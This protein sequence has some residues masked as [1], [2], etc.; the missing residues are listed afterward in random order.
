MKEQIKRFFSE[1]FDSSVYLLLGGAFCG[2]V[3]LLFIRKIWYSM[4]AKY[5]IIIIIG[6]LIACILIYIIW[7]LINHLRILN[8]IKKDEELTEIEKKHTKKKNEKNSIIALKVKIKN[9]L[10][11][12]KSK[13]LFIS[14][15]PWILLIGEPNSGKST[16]IRKSELNFPLGEGSLPGNGGTVNCDWWFT[17][18]AV[19]LDTAGRYTFPTESAPDKAEWRAFLKIVKKKRKYVSPINAVILTISAE[20]LLKN[21]HHDI[22][23]NAILI[24]EKLIELTSYLGITF[25]VY[26]MIS[27]MDQVFGFSEFFSSISYVEKSQIFGLDRKE[28][29]TGPFDKKE[30]RELFDVQTK[31]LQNWALRRAKDLDHY[32]KEDKTFHICSFPCAF[33]YLRKPLELYLKK[34]FQHDSYN[35]NPK[36]M[37]PLMWRG[38]YFSSSIQQE[39]AIFGNNLSDESFSRNIDLINQDKHHEEEISNVLRKSSRPYF[40]HNII[41]KVFSEHN[42]GALTPKKIRNQKIFTTISAICL[43]FII[44]FSVTSLNIAQRKLTELLEPFQHILSGDVKRILDQK[45]SKEINAKKTTSVVKKFEKLRHAI[46]RDNILIYYLKKS[47]ENI[48]IDNLKHIESLIVS[49]GLKQKIFQKSGQCFHEIKLHS[50]KQ[51]ENTVKALNQYLLLMEKTPVSKI[52]PSPLFDLMKYIPEKRKWLDG[53][54][55][56]IHQLWK[57]FPSYDS[58]AYLSPYETLINVRE[59]LERL[60]DY[61][62]L[63]DRDNWQR[64]KINY[65]SLCKAYNKL[66]RHVNKKN[67]NDFQKKT[68]LI[69]RSNKVFFLPPK[70]MM[71]QKCLSDYQ[72]IIHT[73]EGFEKSNIIIPTVYR[74][75]ED[76][77]ALKQDKMINAA[78]ESVKQCEFDIIINDGTINPEL[79]II[80]QALKKVKNFKPI[81]D[82]LK[83]ILSNISIILEGIESQKWQKEVLLSNIVQYC[84]RLVW[85]YHWN[86]FS[87][88]WRHLKK[89]FP[90][91]NASPEI[92]NIYPKKERSS[93]IML[94]DC[95]IE[96]LKNFFFGE[97]GINHIISIKN[98][99]EK[100]VGLPAEKCFY[101]KRSKAFIKNCIQWRNFLFIDENTPRIHDIQLAIN[102][103]QNGNHT[104]A[105]SRFTLLKILGLGNPM[106]LRFSGKAKQNKTSW[107]L[108][109]SNEIIIEAI[110]EQTDGTKDI[111]KKSILYIRGKSLAFPAYILLYGQ[112]SQVFGKNEW[113]TNFKL[114]D[115]KLKTIIN[116]SIS[117]YWKEL[118]DLIKWP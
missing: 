91:R 21:N 4:G 118:P 61:W 13:G 81:K 113:K 40:I 27:K 107:D 59:G 86:K 99:L 43:F 88:Q 31:R 89:R 83:L 53:A 69:P 115:L 25:P 1:M 100:Q 37:I 114:P 52:N 101:T 79:S 92:I 56:D 48:L 41:R 111:S 12:L 65:E 39:K 29:L 16:F 72:D 35:Q 94:K 46:K 50:E 102:S 14:Q 95:S 70:D 68:L 42:L 20:T 47:K 8:K 74:H 15:L 2:A 110:K 85:Q 58:L 108:S 105:S 36:N 64:K 66:L 84:T 17:D 19:I 26:I 55:E 117:I 6:L 73:T 44:I 60:K 51:K 78:W 80:E 67:I 45:Y 11:K 5:A 90:F 7:R 33:S 30:F 23:T 9:A 71:A 63:W 57:Q 54:T 18:E 38:C 10:K 116:A 93:S 75:M 112:K 87:W 32:I 34:I 28:L 77:H 98:E 97:D 3:V 49:K 104:N 103:I 62:E 76:C 96:K 24:R 106:S 109:K 22:E 82:D